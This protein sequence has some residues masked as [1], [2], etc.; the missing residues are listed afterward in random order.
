[1][2]KLWAPWRINYIRGKK[3]KG[4]IFCIGAKKPEENHVFIKTRHSIAILNTF[5]Y[6]S[7]HVMVCPLRHVKDIEQLSEIEILDLFSTLKKAKKMLTETL[8]PEGFN[9]GINLSKPAGA[10]ITNHIHIHIVPRW[11]GD[12]NFMPTL[13]ST[14]VISQ[15]LE[16]LYKLLKNAESKRNK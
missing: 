12:T 11:T 3:K 16:E 7:G 1:M 4:C 8:K 2:D 10:G 13:F 9:I 14:K 15:S 5:P 6:N